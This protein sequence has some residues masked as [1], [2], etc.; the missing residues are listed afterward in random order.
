MHVCAVTR[1]GSAD[2]LYD[3]GADAAADATAMS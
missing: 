2:V 1:L 3:G